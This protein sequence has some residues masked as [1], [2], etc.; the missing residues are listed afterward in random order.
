MQILRML[1][2]PPPSDIQAGCPAD[3]IAHAVDNP[4]QPTVEHFQMLRR[5]WSSRA[6]FLMANLKGLKNVQ[7]SSVEGR[8]FILSLDA[9]NFFY[10]N[11]IY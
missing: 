7:Y 8:N 1:S 6:H 5:Q 2:L 3:F 10:V 4:D 9:C 11:V